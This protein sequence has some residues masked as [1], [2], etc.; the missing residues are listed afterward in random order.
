[1]VL[2]SIC[3]KFRKDPADLRDFSRA[4][5]CGLHFGQA[6]ITRSSNKWRWTKV[7]QQH[8]FKYSPCNDK[9]KHWSNAKMRLICRYRRSGKHFAGHEVRCWVIQQQNQDESPRV[10][11]FCS[12]RWNHKYNNWATPLDEVWNEHGF[13]EP[14]N[15]AARE[16]QFIWHEN[17]DISTLDIQKH[18]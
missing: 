6:R 10:L 8:K 13:D 5:A 1:M 15:L 2:D 7:S 3:A 16:V 9:C 4:A 14:L 17:L 11:R 18:F 12:V